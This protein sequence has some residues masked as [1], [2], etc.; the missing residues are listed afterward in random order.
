M[1]TNKQQSALAVATLLL[2]IAVVIT[3]LSLFKRVIRLERENGHRQ[4]A[5]NREERTR[6]AGPQNTHP[7]AATP[8]STR[9]AQR[10][11]RR[12]SAETMTKAAERRVEDT[13][14]SYAVA[15]P[16]PASVTVLREIDEKT[17]L[18][19]GLPRPLFVGLP[20]AL[21][22]ILVQDPWSG[23]AQGLLVPN[24]TRLVSAGRPVTSSDMSPLIGELAMVTD[25]DKEGAEGSFVEIAPGTQ[26]VQIDLQAVYAI[27]AVALWHYHA[28]A[29]IYHDVV[30]LVSSEPDFRAASVVFN[31]DTNNTLG[32]G[33]GRNQEYIESNKGLL[34][35]VEGITA[36]YVRLYCNGS[37]AGDVNHY[38]EV[39]VYGTGGAQ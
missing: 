15:Q 23:L 30:V 32:L 38:I 29:R 11:P 34:Q 8:S 9:P 37:T 12:R 25:G 5:T 28:E 33:E 14:H 18:I 27:H 13:S 36:R 2:L 22:S 35:G 39:E 19:P 17:F 16:A 20:R 21:Q 7:P 26:W 10:E 3:N 24:G 31:N 4:A 1:M 6:E